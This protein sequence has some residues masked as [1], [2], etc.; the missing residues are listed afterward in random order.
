ML[1]DFREETRGSFSTIDSKY[2]VIHGEMGELKT[3]VKE[4]SHTLK[5]NQQEF[6]RLAEAFVKVGEALAERKA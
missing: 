2:G 1:Q 6:K 5:G 3:V 4:L